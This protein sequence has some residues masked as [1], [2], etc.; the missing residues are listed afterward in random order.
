MLT[1]VNDNS[2]RTTDDFI[3]K[4]STNNI[5]T[6]IIGISEQFRSDICESLTKI[7]GFNYFCA[8]TTGDLKKYLYENFDWTFFP[9]S[10]NIEIKLK[11]KNVKIFEVFGTP[12]SK[13]VNSYNDFAKKGT[14][15]YII[16]K[17]PTSFPS[18]LLVEGGIVKTVGGLILVKLSPQN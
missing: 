4:V 1:D 6:T 9:S 15:S 10:F 3:K 18:E 11:S 8:T 16:T 12:D 13:D 5:H 2:I 14:D 7:K 17:I